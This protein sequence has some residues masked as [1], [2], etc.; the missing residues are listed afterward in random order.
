M[1]VLAAMRDT[2]AL[3][4][5]R[6]MGRHGDMGLEH[7]EDMLKRMEGMD[8][9]K[10][11][12]FLGWAQASV[13]AH[14]CAT[15]DE[16]KSINRTYSGMPYPM[17]SAAAYDVYQK[18]AEKWNVTLLEAKQRVF[19]QLVG[20]SAPP[21]AK[22]FVLHDGED[23]KKTEEL[24]EF[25]DGADIVDWEGD[26]S[27]LSVWLHFGVGDEILRVG[28]SISVGKRAQR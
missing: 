2:V 9:D 16:M 8:E 18:C 4:K 22:I 25:L 17:T 26:N 1:D 14:G 7:I 21:E 12:R 6:Q 27:G 24:H 3:G 19:A 5:L 10:A 11:N 20:T 13:V 23:E 28:N 15:L